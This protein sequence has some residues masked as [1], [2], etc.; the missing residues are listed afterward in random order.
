MS[1]LSR[2]DWLIP[3]GLLT[4]CIVPSLAGS[5]RLVEIA[6]ATEITPHNARFL[7]S[8]LPG[9]LH[10]ASVVLYS[11]LGAFQFMPSLRR[12]RPGWHRMAGRVLVP[13]G[14]VAA[15]TGLWMNAFYALPPTDNAVLYVIRV[16]VGAA[17]TAQLVLGLQAIR[18][19]DF[20]RHEAWM[21]RAY[22]LGLGAGTQVFTHLPWILAVG[23]PEPNTRAVL[24]GAGWAINALVVEWTLR[25]RTG[26]NPSRLSAVPG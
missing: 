8:P 9:V 12:K 2:H 23:M 15:L 1:F 4:L 10:I 13:V 26:R 21:M 14:L 17:M 6:T 25:H 3:A 20:Y 18:R 11:V 24:M 7:A 19:R 16:V 5:V 22:G